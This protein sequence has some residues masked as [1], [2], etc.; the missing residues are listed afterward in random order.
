M[1]SETLPPESSPAAA[2][3]GSRLRW[4]VPLAVGVILIYSARDII[5]PFV[6]A[7]VLAY[8]LDPF[9]AAVHRYTRAPRVLVVIVMALLALVCIG[10]L[11]TLL[12]T[13][14]SRQGGLF[15]HRLP[16]YLDTVVDSINSLIAPTT[17]QIPKS[18]IPGLNGQGLPSISIGDVLSFAASFA[19][20]TGQSLLDFLLTFVSTIYLLL[21]GHHLANGLQRFFPLEHRPRLGRV[22]K[23]VRQ[24]WNSYIRVQIALAAL[25]ALASW[26]IL[27][28]VFGLFG[29]H[30]PF[31]L[32]I[33]IAVGLFETV[34]IVGPLVAITLAA[35][36]AFATLGIFPA[37][38]IVAALYGLRLIEDNVVIPNILGKTVHL[39]AVVTLFAV[40]VGGLVAGLL[41]LLLAVPIAAAIKVVIDEYYPHPP[42]TFARAEAAS[43]QRSPASQAAQPADPAPAAA[44]PEN[45][46]PDQSAS[47]SAPQAEMIMS[48][49]Q[50]NRRGR[51]RKKSEP[52]KE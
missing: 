44:A 36:V 2:S 31:A 21:D 18:A 28:P 41:G 51:N 12:V 33:S 32:P 46:R 4:L 9:V 37:L 23:E 47:A 7:I 38:L 52:A 20:S 14:A 39:P 11:I 29:I 8:L 10:L 48:A 43:S 19:A 15:V 1:A 13:V 24:L 3:M 35:V 45:Q 22:M 16:T 49:T 42:P 40:A 17:V 25:M 34:P 30:L 27:Q 6:I 5:A 26:L 50:P